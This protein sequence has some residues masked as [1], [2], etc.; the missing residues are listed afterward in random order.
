M[1]ESESGDQGMSDELASE[2]TGKHERLKQRI[3]GEIS[4]TLDERARRLGRV[5]SLVL[6]PNG[7]FAAPSGECIDLF[8]DGHYYGCI[9]LAQAVTEAIVRHVWQ[10][11]SRKKRSAEGEFGS[12]LDFLRKKCFIDDA[13][14]DK[15]AAIWEDRNSFHHLNLCL[16]SDRRDLE[17]LAAA[18]LRLA[19]RSRKPLL[20]IC[21]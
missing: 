20:R 15:I 9:S 11:K 14:R 17:E 13:I 10:V 16:E 19:C 18:K 5:E 7:V 1:T 2:E 6:V 3:A 4:R 21:H 8:R 12:N